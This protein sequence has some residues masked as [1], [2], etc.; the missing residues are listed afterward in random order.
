MSYLVIDLAAH[1]MHRFEFHIYWIKSYEPIRFA[2]LS[3][4]FVVA[5]FFS[6][7][8]ANEL[9]QIFFFFKLQK[10]NISKTTE[11]NRTEESFS[12]VK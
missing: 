8:Q 4:H 3:V 2:Q 6:M 7:Y 11:M 9:D 5:F 10:K 12:R 1:Q